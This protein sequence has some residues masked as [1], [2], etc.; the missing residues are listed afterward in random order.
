MYSTA[1][2]EFT[3]EGN[4][5]DDITSNH[6]NIDEKQ[7][8]EKSLQTIKSIQTVFLYEP[9]KD[10]KNYN[11]ILKDESKKHLNM[12]PS[13]RFGEMSLSFGCND[14]ESKFSEMN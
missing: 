10:D 2:K 14:N 11:W 12:P 9:W 3:F 1:K 6:E 8:K 13:P 5:C 4:E 7:P